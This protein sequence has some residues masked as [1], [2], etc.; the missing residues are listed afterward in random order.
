MKIRKGDK[1]KVISGKYKGTEGLVLETF[2]KENKIIVEK[3]NIRRHH[4]KPSQTNSEGG[5]IEKEGKID[6]SNA[7]VIDGSGDKAIVS[8]VGYKMSENGKKV[9]YLKK[10]GKEL[11]S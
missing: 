2:S 6:A 8:R 9:R 7:M 1:V 10:N 11:K 5:I 3:V 4:V